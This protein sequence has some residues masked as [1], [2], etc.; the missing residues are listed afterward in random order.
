MNK[1]P[2]L[3]SVVAPCYYDA[4]NVAELCRRLNNVSKKLETPFEIIIVDDGSP[5]NSWEIIQNLSKQINN[6]IG[7]RLSRNFGQ[8]V[9]ITAGIEHSRGDYVVIMDGDLQDLPEEIPKLYNKILEG[10]DL[11]FSTRKKRMDSKFRYIFSSIYRY[12]INR[13]AGLKIPY[14]I[15]MMRIFTRDW[16]LF[17]YGWDSNKLTLRLNTVKDSVENLILQPGN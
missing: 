14:N 17:L 3:I 6:L 5:D 7:L 16:G 12:F 10:Y 1:N 2:K 8:H 9:A 15:S 11:V 4:G 13:M